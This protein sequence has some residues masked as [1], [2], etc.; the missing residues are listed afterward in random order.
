MI[1]LSVAEEESGRP[2]RP[3]ACSKSLFPSITT[4]KYTSDESIPALADL[5]VAI[6]TVSVSQS[7]FIAA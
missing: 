6:S 5:A 3:N 1:Q 2:A 4:T 7:H